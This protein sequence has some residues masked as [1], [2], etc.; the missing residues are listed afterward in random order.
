MNFRFHTVP[1]GGVIIG[2]PT[3][4]ISRVKGKCYMDTITA[5]VAGVIHGYPPG[6]VERL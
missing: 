5:I 3:V 4:R 6:L 1:A 2:A